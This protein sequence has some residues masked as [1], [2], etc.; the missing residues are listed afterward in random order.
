MVNVWHMHCRLTALLALPRLSEHEVYEVGFVKLRSLVYAVAKYRKNCW[1]VVAWEIRP[2]PACGKK[3]L[4]EIVANFY[5][6]ILSCVS[7]SSCSVM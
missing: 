5:M 1:E 7:Q 2:P 6:Y 4:S 3:L